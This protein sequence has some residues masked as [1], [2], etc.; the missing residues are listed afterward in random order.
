MQVGYSRLAHSKMPISGK[1][2]IGCLR[3]ARTKVRYVNL[4]RSSALL[5]M[6]AGRER[7]SPELAY[8]ST[9]PARSITGFQRTP[10]CSMN[11]RN[12]GAS[13]DWTS[14]ASSRMRF[15]FSGLA[16][17]TLIS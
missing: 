16:I 3:D 15:W 6:R 9:R 1:P 12:A 8:F 4:D 14:M 17:A 2:E 13:M 11:R 5:R 10:S 7:I